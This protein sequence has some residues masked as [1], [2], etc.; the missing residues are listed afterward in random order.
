MVKT[1]LR[2]HAQQAS[3]REELR[4][5]HTEWVKNR[6][7]ATRKIQKFYAN[8]KGLRVFNAFMA[9]VR[10]S[11][12]SKQRQSNAAGNGEGGGKRGNI[13]GR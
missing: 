5:Q 6:N 9:S 1:R 7:I 4:R 2:L 10:N 3:D 8:R 11:L 13:G 12:S